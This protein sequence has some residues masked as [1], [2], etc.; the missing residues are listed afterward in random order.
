[1]SHRAPDP[2]PAPAPS[3]W[4]GLR[5]AEPALVRAVVAAGVGALL[6]WGVDLTEWGDRVSAT[7]ALLFPLI[8]LLQGWWTRT[9]VTPTAKVTDPATAPTT[10]EDGAA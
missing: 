5:T 1:M 3:W 6:I 4:A 8:A 7:W 2:I 10:R 9:V